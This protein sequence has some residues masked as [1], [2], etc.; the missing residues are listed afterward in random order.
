MP[1]V[2]GYGVEIAMLID[3][4]DL[5][6]LDALAQVDLGERT[7]RHQ[8]TE[9]LGR[10]AAQ[11][12]LTAWS[13]LQRQGLGRRR[14]T[15]AAERAD[16]V[17]ARGQNGRCRTS[18]AR[19]SSPTSAVDERPPLTHAWMLPASRRPGRLPA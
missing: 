16:P 7:H 6:G 9:A 5:V 17:P 15:A 19:S 2:S 8:S 11:I 12:M 1:F 13:R 4:L 3:L 10:M 14:V 18:A